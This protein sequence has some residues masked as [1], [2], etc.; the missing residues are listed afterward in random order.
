M[1]NINSPEINNPIGLNDRKQ[2]EFLKNNDRNMMKRCIKDRNYS[3]YPRRYR[4]CFVY[5]ENKRI[6]KKR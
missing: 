2:M 3:I 6:R 4:N 1:E 5:N